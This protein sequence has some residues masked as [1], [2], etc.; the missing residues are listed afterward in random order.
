MR[1][2]I[3]KMEGR[4]PEK[5][6]HLLARMEK[7]GG[8]CFYCGCVL[9]VALGRDDTATFDHVVPR[10]KGGQ[11]PDNLV[12]ACLK[13]NGAKG[14]MPASDFIYLVKADKRVPGM[15]YTT[16]DLDNPEPF[17]PPRITQRPPGKRK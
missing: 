3:A 13:C 11:G 15:V 4:N 7:Q 17:N 8:V 1:A 10:S 14:D 6:K 2:I 5:I 9:T 16:T 12:A